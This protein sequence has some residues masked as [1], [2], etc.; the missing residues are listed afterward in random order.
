MINTEVRVLSHHMDGS[1]GW[2]LSWIRAKTTFLLTD[3]SRGVAVG[4][5]FCVGLFFRDRVSLSVGILEL[6][7]CTPYLL[8]IL[9][10][11]QGVLVNIQIITRG[12]TMWPWLA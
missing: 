7:V 10:S 4:I 12:F 2:C 8:L 9:F 3:R 6:A 1:A 11:R 5:L